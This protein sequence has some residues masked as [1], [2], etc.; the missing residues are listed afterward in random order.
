MDESSTEGTESSPPD[1]TISDGNVNHLS[2]ASESVELYLQRFFHDSGISVP[3][4]PER[5]WK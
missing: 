2:V 1:S 5:V 3:R 4:N